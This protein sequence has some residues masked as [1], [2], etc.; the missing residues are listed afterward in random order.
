M[1]SANRHLDLHVEALEDRQLLAGNVTATLAAGGD[2]TIRGDNASNSVILEVFE[3]RTFELRGLSST[4]IDAEDF[5]GRTLNGNVRVQLRGGDDVFE[6]SGN[7]TIDVLENV[8]IS[9][10]D[11]DDTFKFFRVE[12]GGQL[13]IRAGK[14]DDRLTFFDATAEKMNFN[15]GQGN[16]TQ[17]MVL[18][19]SSR[20]VADQA[21]IKT[22]SGNDDITLR[23]NYESA[24]VSL[25]SGDDVF[26]GTF[27]TADTANINFSGGNDLLVDGG[28]SGAFSFVAKFGS[29]DD[30]ADLTSFFRDI[31]LNGGGGT[32][33]VFAAPLDARLSFEITSFEENNL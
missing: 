17:T 33:T 12:M 2:L 23:G 18:L 11:G 7:S 27:F 32:D 19:N 13:T 5:A 21:I 16:D 29:G 25:G 26:R 8:R 4:T 9:D 10:S 6:L 20:R 30:T 3:D 24:R 22:G 15:L 1:N 14:G 28:F 31:E